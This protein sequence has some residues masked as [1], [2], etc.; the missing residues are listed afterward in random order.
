MRLVAR[1]GFLLL[2]AAPAPA[3]ASPY[4][5]PSRTVH[6]IAAS[7]GSLM[8]VV[9]R[10]LAHRLCE[11]W[12]Q[13]VVVDN[14]P[15]AA[16]TIGTAAAAT[17]KPDGYTLV[18]S[19]RTALAAAPHLM[20]QLPYD[21]LKDLAPVALVATAPLVL[22]GHPSLPAST[23]RELVEYARRNSGLQF[24]SQG[25]TT[26]GHHAGELLR[27]ETGITTEYVHY[28]GAAAA[29]LGLLRGEVLV[30]FNNAPSMFAMFAERRLKAFAVTSRKRLAVA[31]EIPTTAEAG[32]PGV[33]LE[34][35]VGV[36]APAATP[37][38]LLRKLNRE[39]VEVI[40]SP[41]MRAALQAQGAEPAAGTREEFAA[42]LQA[43]YARNKRDFERIGFSAD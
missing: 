4:E 6:I 41:G 7:S 9:A 16:F 40:R 12:G 37:P 2:A 36:L 8:D 34:Y 21:P 43:D 39:L 29:Q 30:G 10:E 14:K 22:S 1:W 13:P 38:A 20:K 11:R 33:E 42:R 32:F 23:M 27:V 17:A 35:W 19:D 3:A 26:T 28:K 15:G 24:S 5:Y 18:M 31:P 25:V